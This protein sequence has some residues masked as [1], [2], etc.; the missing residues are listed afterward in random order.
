M[1]TLKNY[2]DEKHHE[3]GADAGHVRRNGLHCKWIKREI[4]N[5]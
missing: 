2:R 4:Y 5:I 1:K 3:L